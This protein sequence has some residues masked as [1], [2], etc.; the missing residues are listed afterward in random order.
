MLRQH[1]LHYQRS[2]HSLTDNIYIFFYLKKKRF[3]CRKKD[4]LDREIKKAKLAS[5]ADARREKKEARA[6]Q[7]EMQRM[8][9]N[10]YIFKK[11]LLYI[12]LLEGCKS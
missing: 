8:V 4:K 5:L 10:I 7:R 1:L 11:K 2:T 12:L 3:F 6:F 9:K